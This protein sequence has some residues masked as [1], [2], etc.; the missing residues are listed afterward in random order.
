VPEAR[1]TQQEAA[2]RLAKLKYD[3]D[4]RESIRKH[5][6]MLTM[7]EK[8]LFESM[9]KP[10]R[11]NAA[12]YS[13]ERNNQHIWRRGDGTWYVYTKNGIVESIQHEPPE[14]KMVRHPA[15]PC[16]TPREIREAEVSA[17]SIALSHEQKRR[18]HGRVE[19]M[20]QRLREC[21]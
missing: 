4:M 13:G 19:R 16:P 20:R 8:Q 6:P 14:P 17:S 12:N 11:T 2:A 3:N 9:G 5:L 7:S 10:D 21:E 15:E 18:A 1:L